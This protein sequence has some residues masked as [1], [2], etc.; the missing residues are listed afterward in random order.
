MQHVADRADGADVGSATAAEPPRTERQALARAAVPDHL[1]RL[2]WSRERIAAHQREGLRA[3][4]RT[5]LADSPFHA[6][7]LAGI[8][9]DRLELDDLPSLPIMTKAAMMASFDDV[10]T[11]R[12]V[13]R[14]AVEEHLARTGWDGE[15]LFGRSMVLASGG[16]SGERGI[17]VLSRSAAVDYLLA[18]LRPGL[19][20]IV[21]LL[22]RL[23]DEP[24]RV[25]LVAGGSAVH[26]TRALPSLFG[27][28]LMMPTSIPATDPLPVVVDR[29]NQLQP[30]LL[31]GFPSVIRRLADEQLAGRLH[32][33]VLSVASTS[34]SLTPD[35]RARID[36]A[37]GVGVVD[38]FGSSEGL[39][40]L[41]PPDDPTLTLASDLTIV[42]LVDEHDRPVPPGVP[43]AKV[44][45]TNISNPLQPLIRYELTDSF[46][47][48]PD[49][50]TDGHLRV[51]V[52]GRRDDELRFGDV[53]VHPLA[54]RTVLVTSPEVVEYQVRQTT[55]GI[56]IAV[57]PA[58]SCDGVDADALASRLTDSLTR[59]GLDE[60]VVRVQ[61][62]DASAIER[63]PITGKTKRFITR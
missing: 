54:V 24:P 48:Q 63:H 57:V 40:G 42:E 37:F 46:V 29:L 62:V 4:V 6:R 60:P 31:Q 53:I 1:D 55:D 3:L 39:V 36:A 19:A 41:S 43:S 7:R 13:T 25:A 11:D 51:R 16:S 61:V 9:P 12:A 17:F 28:D 49:A 20:R 32:L 18:V 47:R 52:D 21:A 27:G 8:D 56:D 2:T 15:E 38:L 22:G 14:D 35:T 50:S 59:A 10:V 30:L 26:A 5:A 45:L 58:A 23:P 33:N 34:E 44:L